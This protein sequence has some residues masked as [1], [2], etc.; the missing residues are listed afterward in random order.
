M[1]IG[2]LLTLCLTLIVGVGYW[3]SRPSYITLIDGADN[4]RIAD[5]VDALEK[6]GIAYQLGG[7]GGILKVDKQDYANARLIANRQGISDEEVDQSFSSGMWMDPSERDKLERKQKEKRLAE[8]INKLDDIEAVDVNLSLPSKSPFER[9][10]SP[11]TASVVLT[12]RGGVQLTQEQVQSI[13]SLVAYAVEGLT[14]ESVHITDTT[15]RYYPLADARN[16]TVDYQIEYTEANEQRLA[17]KAESQLVRFLGYGNASVQV[18]AAYDFV[19]GTKTT[20]NYIADGRVAENEIVDNTKTTHQEPQAGGSAGTDSNLTRQRRNQDQVLTN[21]ETIESRFLVPKTE[22]IETK[23]TPIRKFMTV[24][25]M[26]NSAAD[27]VKQD[28]GSLITGIKENLESIV[29][30][31]VG[32]QEDKDEISLAFFEFQKPDLVAPAEPAVPWEW[33]NQILK[34]ISLGIAAIIA[35]II[36]VFTWRKILPSPR[37]SETVVRLD[38]DRM[39]SINQLGELIRENPDVFSQLI[40]NWAATTQKGGIPNE[41]AEKRARAA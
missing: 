8:T 1:G 7:A 39:S 41:G 10:T 3:S 28:D 27:R 26:V 29:K 37:Q 16:R 11:P 19:D 31:A 9:K 15:G 20:T 17:R 34:N 14:P 36:G 33:I 30:T 5:L 40:K 21:K 25:V 13:G 23:T 22:E 6:E 32:F 24:S 18:S 4:Q 38:A 12:L 2:L 35:L